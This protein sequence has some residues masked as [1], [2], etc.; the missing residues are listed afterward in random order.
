MIQ[1]GFIQTL[2]QDTYN[3]IK[4]QTENISHQVSLKQP[5]HDGN[6]IY[7]I[8]GHLVVARCNFLMML[9]VPSIWSFDQCRN[10]IP[11]SSSA[12]RE[13]ESLPYR[14]M[15]DGLDRTQSLLIDALKHASAKDLQRITDEQT[16]AEH[17]LTY[18]A[19][20]SYHLGQLE[21]LHHILAASQ[22][23]PQKE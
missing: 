10:F 9:N 4:E 17:L 11:G 22:Q 20:E 6:T 3:A 12:I 1:P 8:T 14:T 18:H 5:P 21:I 13:T 16:I 15:L 19:H 23:F 7:W 2:F